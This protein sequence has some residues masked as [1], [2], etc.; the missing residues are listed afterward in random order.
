MQKQ[1]DAIAKDRAQ[2]GRHRRA[3]GED[4]HLQLPAEPHHRPPH[5]LHDAPAAERPRR[6]TRRTARRGQTF[7]YQAEKLKEVTAKRD[8]PRPPPR[9]APAAGGAPRDPASS[10]AGRAR[11]RAARARRARLGAAPCSRTSRTPRRKASSRRSPPASS[12]ARRREPV[13]YILGVAGVLGPRFRGRRPRVLIPRPETELIVEE[14][15]R[16]A[17]PDSRLRLPAPGAV[18]RRHRHR[19]R[20]PGRDARRRTA[21]RAGRRDRHLEPRRSTWPARMP[22][23]HGV[24]DR[25]DVPR[26]T[27]PRRARRPFDVIVS[28]PPYVTDADY[29]ALAPEVRT[30]EPAEALAAAP[31]GLRDIREILARAPAALAPGGVL[32]MEIGYGQADAVRAAV[33]G[34]PAL[35]TARASAKTSRAS[36]AR[37]CSS[38]SSA[39]APSAPSHRAPHLGTLAPWHLWHHAS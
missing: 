23:R 9:R 21:R 3:V 27:L 26:R 22:A 39:A 30:F 36:P 5:Q 12:A 15:V 34:I 35:R 24:A 10:R 32:L 33:A 38:A 11:R 6:R 25:V 16:L 20:L 7:Y 29:A 4:P 28:N 18:G 31:D 17:A 8:D 1:Q 2:P 14:A 19:Q 13:A 37:S